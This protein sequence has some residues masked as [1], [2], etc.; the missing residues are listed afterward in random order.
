VTTNIVVLDE[1]KKAKN[2]L[3]NEPPFILVLPTKDVAT[4]PDT[5]GL[6]LQVHGLDMVKF[7]N[8][9]LTAIVR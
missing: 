5:N 1:E 9:D 4:L 2:F 8:W 3:T 7:K 6:H